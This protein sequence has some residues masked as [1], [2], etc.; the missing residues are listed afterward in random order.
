M[1]IP[2]RFEKPGKA[3]PTKFGQRLI[4]MWPFG[5]TSG[6]TVKPM[7][8]QCARSSQS[9]GQRKKKGLGTIRGPSTV[10]GVHPARDRDPFFKPSLFQAVFILSCLGEHRQ[11]AVV[12]VDSDNLR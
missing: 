11:D 12:N 4:L 10:A 8:L 6:R 3:L 5:E 7:R 9:G 1:V 2:F